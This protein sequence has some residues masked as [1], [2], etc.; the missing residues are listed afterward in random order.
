MLSMVWMFFNVMFFYVNFI[1]V[2]F[3]IKVFFFNNINFLIDVIDKCLFFKICLGFEI[4]CVIIC[5]IDIIV[6]IF[7]VKFWWVLYSMCDIII[8]V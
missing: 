2:V 1:Y 5:V 8:I 3:F 6:I 7:K 4:L